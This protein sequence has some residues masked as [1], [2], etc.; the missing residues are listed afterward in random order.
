MPDVLVRASVQTL[1]TGVDR[2][3]TD[4]AFAIDGSD[5]APNVDIAIIDTGVG[6]HDDLRIAGG[7]DFT[8]SGSYADGNIHGTHVAGIRGSHRQWN[9]RGG[10]LP[11][12]HGHTP[13]D[14][15]RVP[16]LRNDRGARG[17]DARTT[18]ATSSVDAGRT[19]A[20]QVPR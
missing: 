9:R 3:D 6:P 2:V 4:Q 15:S 17:A 12:D 19:T 18:A 20:T 13:A 11:V 8:G 1:P 5:D 14:E 16:A 10:R 7:V